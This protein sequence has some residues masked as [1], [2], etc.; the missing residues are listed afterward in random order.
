MGDDSIINYDSYRVSIYGG[1]GNDRILNAYYLGSYCDNSYINGDEGDDTISNFG[2]NNSIYGG[3]GN[4]SIFTSG[5]NVKVDSGE[6]NDNIE[7]Y[8][9]ENTTIIGG[10][11][12]D[13]ISLEGENHLIQYNIGDGEDVIYGYSDSD[14]IHITNG[15][16]KDTVISDKGDLKI[17]LDNGSITLIDVRNRTVTLKTIDESDFK[18]FV[19]TVWRIDGTTASYVTENND[20][21]KVKGLKSNAPVSGISLN[22]NVVTLSNSVLNQSKVTVSEGYTLK[23]DNDVVESYTIPKGWSVSGTTATYNK[24]R[25]YAGYSLSDDGKTINYIKDS[26]GDTLYTITGLKNNAPVSGISL[27][28]GIVLSN[29]V[30]DKGTVTITKI[31]STYGGTTFKLGD[32][33]VK[34]STTRQGWY[35]DGTTATYKERSISEGYYFSYNDGYTAT[36]EYRNESVEGNTLITVTGIKDNASRTGISLSGTEVILYASV[37]D[38][39]TVKVSEGYTLKLA[40]NVPK[41]SRNSA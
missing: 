20:I 19:P 11:G 32:D 25:T 21:L 1:E 38:E 10:L 24:E 26:G 4:D 3:S 8:S 9:Y 12:D 6:G 37:L 2:K 5:D 34:S 14:T 18:I 27:S 35:V 41:A 22:G 31:N 28:G 30:L 17:V 16:I 29:S 23:L 13:R 7:I 33:V 15:A 40:N 36:I 39:D